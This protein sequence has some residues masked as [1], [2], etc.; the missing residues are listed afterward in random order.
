MAP[1]A[2]RSLTLVCAVSFAGM[3]Q[4]VESLDLKAKLSFHADS[5]FSPWALAGSAAYAGI[6]QAFDT[7]HVWGQGA[8]GYGKRFASTVGGS[9]VHG[10]LAFGLDS[11]LH[12][13]P[14][15]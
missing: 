10:A 3:A 1:M 12:Q 11:A 5:V 2:I 14:R 9:A 6:L 4:T 7:P 13:D 15:Y 8:G